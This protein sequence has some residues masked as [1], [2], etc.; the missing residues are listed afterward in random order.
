MKTEKKDQ[1]VPAGGQSSPPDGFQ[2]SGSA[3]VVGWFNMNKLGNVLSG[4]LTGM[5]T[6]KDA[7]RTEGTSK[8][9]QVQVD[10]ECE[11]RAE[12][13]EDVKYIPALPGQSV[14]VNYGPKTKPWED[15]MPDIRNGAVYAVF[16]EI[17]GGKIKIS[18]GRQMHNFDVYHKQV[19]PPKAQEDDPLEEVFESPADEAQ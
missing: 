11:V 8:F 9:F 13:G 7:L 14:N 19:V 3:A 12:R 18:G 5:F 17:A 2:R 6:R 1:A 4:K 10:K 15:F 16:G